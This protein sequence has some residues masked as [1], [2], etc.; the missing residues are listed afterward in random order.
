MSVGLL[1]PGAPS[2]APTALIQRAVPWPIAP[3]ALTPL[4]F[5]EHMSVLR[6]L[7]DY[8]LGGADTPAHIWVLAVRQYPSAQ[9]LWFEEGKGWW[10]LKTGQLWDAQEGGFKSVAAPSSG[11]PSKADSALEQALLENAFRVAAWEPSAENLRQLQKFQDQAEQQAE[12]NPSLLERLLS[13][14]AEGQNAYKLGKDFEHHL[15]REGEA[16]ATAWLENLTPAPSARV[17]KSLNITLKKWK[18]RQQDLR[19][20]YT[21][22]PSSYQS[23]LPSIKLAHGAAHPNSLRH[24]PPARQWKILLDESG[25]C[26]D[27]NSQELNATNSKL[28]RLV[29]I[30]LPKGT[31]L[32]PILGGFH[33]NN[34]PGPMVDRVLG[35]LLESGA[36]IFGFTVQDAATQAS[37]W[38]AHMT[39][40]VRWTLLQL[41]LMPDA[42]T[43]V[44]VLIEKRGA[45]TTRDSLKALSE[46]LESEFRALDKRFAQLRLSMSF[47]DKHDSFNGYVDAVA[48]TWGS[49]A[50]DSQDRLKRSAL[51]GHCLLRPTDKGLE[52]LYLALTH[53][54]K[55]A[56]A[57]WYA[58][59]A[60]S[61][62][63]PMMAEFLEQLGHQVSQDPKRWYQYLEEV[64]Q[65][66]R[67]KQFK[68]SEIATVLN[69][70]ERWA[71]TDTQLPPVLR[72]MLESAQLAIEN[73]HGKTEKSRILQCLA[74]STQVYDEAAP[75]ACEALL[76]LTAAT[77]N[78]FEFDVLLSSL[79]QWAKE[80]V[81][82][83]GLLNHAKVLS[84][85]GQLH[86]FEGRLQEADQAFS[87]ALAAFGRLTDPSQAKRE[88]NQTRNYQLIARM[89]NPESPANELVA[90]VVSYL[91]ALLHKETPEAISRSLAHSGQGLHY[92]HHLWLRTLVRYPNE[93]SSARSAYLEQAHQ[94]QI[95]TSH[96]WGLIEA[97]RSWLLLEAGQ[98]EA[99]AKSMQHAIELCSQSEYGFTLQWMAEVFRTWAQVLHLSGVEGPST[100]ERERLKQNLPC[101][102]HEA[103][104]HFA[105]LPPQ[106]SHM[107]CLEQLSLCLP[108]NFH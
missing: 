97:Y 63:E 10:N 51:L 104:A 2:E 94:W 41:P 105:M 45:Y 16:A 98:S 89:D 87:K 36:G 56:P 85:I 38:M 21:G 1:L 91:G 79:E 76:R 8:L 15:K 88:Q 7:P 62:Q 99:A 53:R 49:P 20:R 81:A 27:A 61:G 13:T 86:A 39:L 31:Q 25:A 68:L 106:S 77:T 100:E 78:S 24:L 23:H 64:R 46:V 33:A 101:A 4:E 43:K 96:P 107:Q 12:F 42:E 17:A 102:P 93:L 18:E 84:S 59:C 5:R 65:H 75:E 70:L 35:N 19:T 92:E 47:M 44:E 54:E 71:P 29:A 26:F 69:W 34:Q 30:A 52:R 9:S 55:L 90:E 11:A 32:P 103:L 50:A 108:F 40:L 82:V 37:N 67:L 6:P 28:G 72:L 58:L 95:E 60:A 22:K 48:F 14:I 57:D 3:L 83:P 73:H 74:L 66:L 80:P